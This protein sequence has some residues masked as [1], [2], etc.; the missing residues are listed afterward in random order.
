[1]LRGHYAMDSN[2]VA[3]VSIAHATSLN[4]S[5]NGTDA[6]VFD[7]DETLLSNLRYYQ[8]RR[9]GGQAFDETSFDNWVDLGK[10]PALSASYGVYTHLLELGIK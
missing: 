1:M 2:T 7:V 8:A 10:A 6:W 9:F 4:L 3:D 5:K